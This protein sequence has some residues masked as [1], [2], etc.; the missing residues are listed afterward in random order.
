[1][2]MGQLL[3]A[4]IFEVTFIGIGVLLIPL[5]YKSWIWIK[6]QETS[7]FVFRWV[8][9]ST[10]FVLV[11]V[12]VG[13]ASSIWIAFLLSPFDSPRHSFIAQL[14]Q[15]FWMLLGVLLSISN[16]ATLGGIFGAL[17]GL[18]TA[19]GVG[20]IIGFVFGFVFRLISNPPLSGS[21]EG[22]FD[23]FMAGIFGALFLSIVAAVFISTFTTLGGAIVGL[24]ADR[25]G[26]TGPYERLLKSFRIN[27]DPVV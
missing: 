7:L 11:W 9:V 5:V 8:L 4:F 2:K 10:L 26:K 27:S 22:V 24:L 19:F 12:L 13:I 18:L 15:S 14:W 1:M 16:R 3:S 20:S 21:G 17:L 25:F 6:K 23:A